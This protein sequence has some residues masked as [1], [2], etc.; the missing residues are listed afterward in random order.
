MLV[1]TKTFVQGT[2]V[3]I[4]ISVLVN[5]VLTDATTISITVKKPDDSTATFGAIH[6]G[7]GMYHCPIDTTAGP[8]GAWH[9]HVVSTGA[10]T[11]AGQGEF[12]V[13][14]NNTLPDHT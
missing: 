3:T 4:G 14:E 1:R 5:E 2:I 11:G 6:D 13:E 7:A 10:A 9:Y 12:I 8:A